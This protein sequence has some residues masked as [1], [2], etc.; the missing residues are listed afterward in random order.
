MALLP[1]AP[2]CRG[3]QQ[4]P[5]GEGKETI[6]S[7]TIGVVT[8]HVGAIRDMVTKKAFKD[9]VTRVDEGRTQIVSYLPMVWW[10]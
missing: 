7:F 10:E 9:T 3:S 8:R 2:W 5:L 1:F 6:T 4:K